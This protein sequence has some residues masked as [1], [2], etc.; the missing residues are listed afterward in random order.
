M[1]NCCLI[2]SGLINKQQI[3][4]TPYLYL[5]FH[6]HLSRVSS[7]AAADGEDSNSPP[8]PHCSTIVCHPCRPRLISRLGGV[9]VAV[10]V[11]GGPTP[12]PSA[13]TLTLMPAPPPPSLQYCWWSHSEV[14]AVSPLLPLVLFGD[15]DDGRRRRWT[16][17]PPPLPAWS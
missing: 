17:P 13:S 7:L 5:S 2:S 6:K 9:A 14:E 15:D 11:A 4:A 12:R 3:K 1:A 10:A 8:T 16:P